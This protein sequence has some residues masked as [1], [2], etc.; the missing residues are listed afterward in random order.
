[1]VPDGVEVLRVLVPDGVEV[2]R[3]LEPGHSGLDQLPQTPS[4]TRTRRRTVTM[5]W[6]MMPANL[7]AS[8]GQLLHPKPRP[9]NAT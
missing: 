2:L 8:Q 5:S 3:V 7:A 4:L 1:M 6:A 9:V